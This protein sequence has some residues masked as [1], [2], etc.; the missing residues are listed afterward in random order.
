MVVCVRLLSE[1][2]ADRPRRELLVD[3]RRDRTA[4]VQV[5]AVLRHPGPYGRQR[6]EHASGLCQRGTALQQG[7]V[8]AQPAHGV[9]R[10]VGPLDPDDQPSPGADVG[11]PLPP[12]P[13]RR[14]GRG[15]GHRAGVDGCPARHQLDAA[16]LPRHDV[17]GAPGGAGQEPLAAR[18]E[19][20][21][22]ATAVEAGGVEAEQARQDL[23]PHRRRQ[24]AEVVGRA[25]GHV[26]EVAQRIPCPR[27]GHTAPE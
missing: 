2:Q 3:R 11:E 13:G 12:L 19:R 16:A 23:G 24:H 27:P 15:A 9:L 5:V 14:A 10:R 20:L 1:V 18:P 22:P 4:L 21:E 26:V 7:G 25:P 6:G 17:A 8:G